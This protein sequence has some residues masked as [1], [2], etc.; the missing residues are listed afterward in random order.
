MKLFVLLIFFTAADAFSKTVPLRLT[1]KEIEQIIYLN[2]LTIHRKALYRGMLAVNFFGADFDITG[3][4]VK[5]GATQADDFFSEQ[6]ADWQANGMSAPYSNGVM[7]ELQSLAAALVHVPEY[8][9]QVELI[10]IALQK[11]Q[12]LLQDQEWLFSVEMREELTEVIA[13]MEDISGSRSWDLLV[14]TDTDILEWAEQSKHLMTILTEILLK[15]RIGGSTFTQ[16]MD[17]AGKAYEEFFNELKVEKTEEEIYTAIAYLSEASKLEKLFRVYP[18]DKEG[19]EFDNVFNI[20]GHSAEMLLKS[21]RMEV[22]HDELVGQFINGS[23]STAEF[24]QK[25]LQLLTDNPELVSADKLR[26]V[27]QMFDQ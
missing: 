8:P 9:E 7:N 20:V 3:K 5:Y 23:I 13:R 25:Y 2:R 1:N 17:R 11:L 10:N 15:Q 27:E 6:M 24:K 16:I 19:G 26:E 22:T 18:V 4:F 21:V 14:F 12:Q